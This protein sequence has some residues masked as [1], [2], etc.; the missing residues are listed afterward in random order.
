MTTYRLTLIVAGAFAVAVIA[1][2]MS[3][4]PAA[5]EP[6]LPAAAMLLVTYAAGLAIGRLV[7][8]GRG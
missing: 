4:A 1:F 6:L 7:W 5:P 2:A 8:K 3:M